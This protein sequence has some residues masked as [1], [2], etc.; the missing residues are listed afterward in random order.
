MGFLQLPRSY[1]SVH[2]G[3]MSGSPVLPDGG[4]RMP[5]FMNQ[6]TQGEALVKVLILGYRAD[7]ETAFS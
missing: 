2:C 6:Q 3:R 5:L 4:V 1:S 7:R